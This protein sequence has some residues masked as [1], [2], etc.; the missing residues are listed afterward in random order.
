[1]MRRHAFIVAFVILVPSELWA[2]A[3]PARV[4][5]GLTLR[6]AVDSALRNSL[7]L[8]IARSVADSAR[9]ETRI[10]RALPNPIFASIP[11]VPFQ[12]SAALPL[13][14]GP[15]R[16]FRV[17]ASDLGALAAQSDAKENARQVV[18]AVR[19]AYLDV[20]LADDRR[21]V[22]ASR[23]DIMRQLVTADSTRVRAG[24]LPERLLIRSEVELLRAEADFARAGVDAQ[25]TRL[26]LQAVMGVVAPDTAL[27][28]DGDLRYHDITFTVDRDAQSVL[29]NRPDVVASRTRESLSVAGQ[30][31]AHA[32]AFPIPQLS[33][34]RQLGGPFNSGHD[35][36]FGVGIE[37]PV[38]NR[39]AGQRE[40]ADA[41][42]E[43]A[44]YARR[45][46]ES[47]AVREVRS[48]M[49]EFRAQQA[50]VQ[51]YESG[52]TAKVDQSVETARYAYARGASSLLD[53]L[54]AVRARQD[55][56][57]EYRTA[58]HD[59]WVAVYAV[60][61]AAGMPER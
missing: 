18:F 39:Y 54:D 55:V 35:Y 30:G 11:N 47:Q 52:V 45:K 23:R 41:V 46:V 20:L 42:R 21:E 17:Q 3:A 15:Q 36:A 51:R 13:D 59:Y 5:S 16:H 24:D 19:R 8:R 4:N 26:S 44:G 32:L 61:A 1:M 34:V 53:V 10:A 37:V 12:Y 9:S 22:I 2:Q 60:E 14:I 50:L 40:R 28:L 27:R 38:L 31:I 33:Y 7:D 29:S 58:L 25:G 49:A 48:A 43:A 6:G 56:L 57:T